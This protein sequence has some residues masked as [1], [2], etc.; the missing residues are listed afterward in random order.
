MSSSLNLLLEINFP[1]QRRSLFS[2]DALFYIQKSRQN[3]L[4]FL[5]LEVLDIQLGTE[6]PRDR[7]PPSTLVGGSLTRQQGYS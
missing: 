1:D 3:E 5:L 7:W 6:I 4:T 2:I